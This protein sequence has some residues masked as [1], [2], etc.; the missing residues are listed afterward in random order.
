[1]ENYFTQTD[2]RTIW[3]EKFNRETYKISIENDGKD[4]YYVVSDESGWELD[5][6]DTL[7]EAKEAVLNAWENEEEESPLFENEPD[8]IWSLGLVGMF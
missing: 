5:C 2:S 1:M 6:Y 4:T 8:S 7:E 3:G